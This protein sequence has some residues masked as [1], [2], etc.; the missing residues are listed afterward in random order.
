MNLTPFRRQL[1]SRYDQTLMDMLDYEPENL[2]LNG[3]YSLPIFSLWS[4]DVDLYEK[5]SPNQIEPFLKYLKKTVRDMGGNFQYLEIGHD[6]MFK[7]KKSVK[8]ISIKDLKN[9]I[10]ITDSKRAFLQLVVLNPNTKMLEEV[11]IMYELARE[12]TNQET[13]KSLKEDI[14]FY[15][16][17]N[18]YKALK[19]AQLY[20]TLFIKTASVGN[21]GKIDKAADKLELIDNI[22][23]DPRNGALYKSITNLNTVIDAKN[24]PIDTKL[25]VL[26]RIKG[27][28]RKLDLMRHQWIDLF[29]N[30]NKKN[31]KKVSNQLLK[32]LNNRVH[33]QIAMIQ[34]NLL[35]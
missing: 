20:Y 32:E 9:M 11:S 4:G 33:I 34:L 7:T 16:N 17:A 27:D 2:V 21:I 13:M 14:S 1:F 28:L 15:E 29:R 24:K 23:R 31:L 8:E 3:S 30:F 35:D 18:I 19:R 12:P 5:I 22:L 25:K 6:F 26:D 10:E